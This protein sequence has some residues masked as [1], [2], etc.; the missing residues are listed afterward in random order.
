[1]LKY[2]LSLC[3]LISCSIVDYDYKWKDVR[4]NKNY[5]DKIKEVI[6]DKSI[7]KKF[8][9]QRKKKKKY[10]KQNKRF[11]KKYSPKF[12]ETDKISEKLWSQTK[13]NYQEGEKSYFSLDY[14][15]IGLGTISIIVD[16][17]Q[18]VAGQECYHVIARLKS[19]SYYSYLYKLNDYVETFVSKSRNT[20]VKYT[21]I[22]EESHKHVVD[23]QLYDHE[24]HLS[25]FRYRRIKNG[26]KKE[27]KKDI[28]IP[29]YF[30]DTLSSLYFLRT[31]PSFNKGDRYS[32][33]VVIKTKISTYNIEVLGEEDLEVPFGEFLT[34]KIR[35][36][37]IDEKGKMKDDLYFWLTKSFERNIV[38]F[39]AT[40]KIGHVTGELEKYQ[41]GSKKNDEKVL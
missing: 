9:I 16:K 18:D 39:E 19:A 37:I 3:F 40:I 17:S 1:M 11:F 38:K 26:V 12:E 23:V 4:G 5:E 41:S 30:Q 21:L 31:L 13:I 29:V 14:L 10:I 27:I 22:Q 8:S 34:T 2:L 24:K 15:G 7:K 20:P 35:I 25:Y 28:D 32:F 36:R 6:S 33:P